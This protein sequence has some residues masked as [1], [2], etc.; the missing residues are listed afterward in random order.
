[1]PS[2]PFTASLSR[3][4]ALIALAAGAAPALAQTQTAPPANGQLPQTLPGLDNFTIAPRKPLPMPIPAPTP[5]PTPSP[6]QVVPIRPLP[7]PSPAPTPRATRTPAARPTPAPAPTPSPSA[8]PTP[9]PGAAVSTPPAVAATPVAQPSPAPTSAPAATAPRHSLWW[10]ALFIA[11]LLFPALG[12]VLWFV[13]RSQWSNAAT[14][15]DDDD[16]DWI[17]PDQV[18]PPPPSPPAPAPVAPPRQPP[19]TATR[20]RLEIGFTPRSAGVT[21]NA[22]VD[23][24][25]VVRNVGAIAA[26]GVQL[27]V[28]LITAGETHD[29]EL[30]ARLDAPIDKPMIAP[31]TLPPGQ[32]RPIRALAQL[33]KSAI[34]VVTVQGRP[35]FVPIVAI[36]LRYRWAT[37]E[38]QTAESFVIGIAPKEG[39]RMRPFWLDVPARMY[40]T[41]TARPHSVGAKR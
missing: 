20:P 3:R 8:T 21:A 34:N 13:R 4:L 37:G 14:A 31:F 18:A 10:I 27:R 32:Q 7:T 1:M 33:P 16:D 11:L 30:Q 39:E 17:A 28:E 15:A 35:M 29:A 2:L 36:D 24:D 22:A 25:L 6:A 26:E 38:G 5:T 40:D 41:V 19:G 12:V 9:A 23:Y